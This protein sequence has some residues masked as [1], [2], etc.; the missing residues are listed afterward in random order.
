MADKK[1]SSTSRIGRAG[2]VDLV[3]STAKSLDAKMAESYANEIKLGAQGAQQVLISSDASVISRENTM[4]Y[5]AWWPEREQGGW[6]LPQVW[7]RGE[8]SSNSGAAPMLGL[9]K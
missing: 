9:R 4:F 2:T 6:L 7:R 8:R 1:C 3:P 5:A